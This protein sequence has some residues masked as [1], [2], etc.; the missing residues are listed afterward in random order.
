MASTDTAAAPDRDRADAGSAGAVAFVETPS[1]L[2]SAGGY[3]FRTRVSGLEAYAGEVLAREPLHDLIRRAEYI[4]G[5]P[6]TLAVWL[7]VALLV[8]MPPLVAVLIAVGA[9]VLASLARPLLAGD[10]LAAVLRVLENPAVQAFA[11][12][13]ALSMLAARGEI[14]AVVVGLAGFIVLRWGGLEFLLARPM[15]KVAAASYDLP[16]PDAVLRAL[17]VRAAIRLGVPQ[18]DADALTRSVHRAVAK[19]PGGT[20]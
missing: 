1:G 9:Y 5:L 17:L 19:M 20:K 11:Y 4:L 3:W 16:M 7:L 10:W 13:F 15:D 6:K 14:T 2:F 8:V 12:V 18:P